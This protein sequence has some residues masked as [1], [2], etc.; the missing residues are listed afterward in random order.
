MGLLI[1][2]SLFIAAERS[3]LGL[4]RAM[5]LDFQVATADARDFPKIP[6]LRLQL[7]RVS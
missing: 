5:A 1:D 6:N 4:E 2:S 7:W 3:Q